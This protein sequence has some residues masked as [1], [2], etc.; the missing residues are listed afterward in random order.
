MLNH[1]VIIGRLTKDPMLRKTQKGASVVSFTVACSRK[2]AKDQESQTDYIN[3]VSWNKTA[4]AINTYV[5]KGHL[6]GVSGHIQTRNY[7]DTNGKKQFVT[8]VMC[9]QVVFLESK[10]NTSQSQN[11]EAS[12]QYSYD[13]PM[14]ASF[15][16]DYSSAGL[17]ISSDD[18]PF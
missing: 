1:V 17:D 4:D 7:E 13:Q 6:I 2:V 10:K 11:N 18:L 3:C 9:E 8:E 12:Q 14:Q 16:P 5:R 15:E